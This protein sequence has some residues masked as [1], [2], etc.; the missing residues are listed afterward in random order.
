MG[1]VYQLL[2]NSKVSGWVWKWSLPTKRAMELRI[3]MGRFCKEVISIVLR[4]CV[5]LVVSSGFNGDSSLICGQVIWND[6]RRVRKVGKVFP[7]LASRP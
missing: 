5:N 7:L 4:R 3:S 1:I 6:S 2:N